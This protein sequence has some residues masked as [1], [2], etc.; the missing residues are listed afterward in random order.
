M[1]DMLMVATLETSDSDPKTY[2]QAMRLPDATSWLE[3]CAAEVASLVENKVFAVVDRP[4]SHQTITSKWVFKKQRG[5]TGAVEKYK[6]RIVARGFM[7][8]EGVDYGETYSPTVRFESIR[9]MLAAA[10]SDGLHM[11]KLDVSTAF[12][13]ADLE[14]VVYLEIPEG[15]FS[16]A[17]SSKEKYLGE[18]LQRFPVE[19]PRSASTPL[20]PGCKLS[21]LDSPQTAADKAKMVVIPYRS[22]IGSLMSLA[23]RVRVHV[24]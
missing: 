5:L 9:M 4:A 1:A 18:V 16:E 19:N 17:M 20:P 14:E 2:K 23:R 10:A 24:C 21:N 11:E 15:M 22:A 6:A 8:E 3:A 7:Q 12:L 13:Y